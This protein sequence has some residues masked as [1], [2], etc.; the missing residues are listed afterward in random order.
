MFRWILTRNYKAL[1]KGTKGSTSGFLNV[2]MEL[3]KCCNHCY[4]IKPPDEN[5]FYNRQ[6]G[7]QVRFI[8]QRGS[9]HALVGLHSKTSNT[10]STV[11]KMFTYKNFNKFIYL[12]N[13][14]SDICREK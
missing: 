6:E 10:L 3:K 9:T 7:L 11:I 13:P 2:M 5:E 8:L 12:Q 4:L 1:S 14:Q